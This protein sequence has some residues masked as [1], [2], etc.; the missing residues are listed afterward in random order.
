ME[1]TRTL[2]LYKLGNVSK[3]SRTCFFISKMELL[4]PASICGWEGRGDRFKA[5]GQRYALTIENSNLT[6]LSQLLSWWK[7]HQAGN[8][9][10]PRD[11]NSTFH[12][13]V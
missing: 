9:L 8:V 6:V 7:Q 5:R 11:S 2:E 12:L 1:K 4:V 3:F 13:Y 10:A